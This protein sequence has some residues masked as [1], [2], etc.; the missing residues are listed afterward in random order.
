MTVNVARDRTQAEN[1]RL[2]LAARFR[3]QAIFLSQED[4]F[5][6]SEACSREALRIRPDD[7]DALNALGVAIWRQGRPA[8]AEEIYLHARRIKPDDFRV[9]TNLGL[10]LY[11]QGRIDEARNCY[12]RALEIQPAAFDA[13]MNLGIVLSDQG[14]FDEAT[15]Y[16]RAAHELRPNSADILQNFGMNLGR[17]GRWNDVI[18]FY[19][20]ALRRVPDSPEV[21][22][23]LAYALLICGDY[24]R[25]WPEYEWRFRCH[26]YP[27]YKI[28]R[29]FW[30][31]D[32]LRDR[33]ILLHPEQGYGDLLQFIR[34]AALV[35]QRVG[36]VLV[37][38][39][40]LLLKLVARCRG[41]DMAFEC[42]SYEPNCDV[43]APLMSLPAIFGTTLETLPAQV[44]YLVTEKVLVDHWGA[45]LARATAIENSESS[46][47]TAQCGR[48]HHERPFRIGINWQGNPANRTDRWRSFRLDNFA[49]LAELPGVQLISLQAGH[50]LD[51]LE[52][53]D[54]QFPV[55]D[56]PGR[57]YRD[58]META[59]IMHHLDL[60]ITP[61][62]ALAH[63]AG[64][65]GLR[66]WTGLSTVQ[67]WPGW[68]A[69]KTR[70]GIPPCGCF[71]RARSATG[72]ASSGGCSMRSRKNSKSAALAMEG[73]SRPTCVAT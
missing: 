29:I 15:D 46:T 56:L 50:G 47:A 69:A 52:A 5:A 60:V 4:R 14:K 26:P 32:T 23:N 44:P 63:L 62:T 17:Q 8:E 9:M 49:P 19:E 43:H 54:R 31:G 45:E 28:N 1:V 48:T 27:G 53:A 73:R 55:I 59:A 37:L 20:Q 64:A 21:H 65:L 68:S 33:T 16:L 24:A 41:V 25:G 66:V 51:Q 2:D 61:D 35:K 71:A 22:L 12:L 36:R 13:L 58:F 42:G 34:F 38:C 30:N 18:D 11:D 7:V 40:A 57:R 72:T 67:D 70:R 6:E 10:A 3:D 39:P